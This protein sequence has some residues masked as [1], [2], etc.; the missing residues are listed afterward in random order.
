MPDLYHPNAHLE[1]EV[2]ARGLSAA[3]NAF[4]RCR[5]EPR[6]PG[7][8]AECNSLILGELIGKRFVV[9]VRITIEDETE[10]GPGPA[11][12]ALIDAARELDAEP[13]LIRVHMRRVG[14]GTSFAYFGYYEFIEAVLGNE[15][16]WNR[17]LLPGKS[18][19]DFLRLVAGKLSALRIENV[20]DSDC[21]KLR[22][23]LDGTEPYAGTIDAGDLLRS[24]IR[25]DEYDIFTCSCG[26]AG[27][28]GIWRGVVVVNDGPLTLWKA[29][30]AKGRRVFV[31]DRSQYRDE[32]LLRVK[33]VV[34]F[35]RG[36]EGRSVVP[37]EHGFSY[38]EK[39]LYE[40]EEAPEQ[41]KAAANI[42]TWSADS[43]PPDSINKD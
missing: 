32:I 10:E 25:S 20:I 35:V 14:G 41:S 19:A 2:V 38:L 16:E 39:A 43:G 8:G 36:G 40:A 28:A 15:K 24:T 30:Y 31:F 37:Y 5:M 12:G 29:Y 42:L 7:A 3:A 9:Y 22:L 34:Q 18:V 33:E 23:F 13:H 26:V 17:A 4:R 1:A 11:P 21:A 27:C 6:V